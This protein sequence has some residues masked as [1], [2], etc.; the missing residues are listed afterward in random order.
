MM[1]K[2]ETVSNYFK[3]ILQMKDQVAAIGDSVDDAE[4]VTTTLNVFP[5][6][7]D[8]FVQGICARGKLS[9]FDKLWT[10]CTY[11]ESRLISKSQKTNDE[12][13]QALATHVKKRKKCIADEG[14]T[15]PLQRHP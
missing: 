2:S 15:H 7:W 6:S 4:L 5:S 9:K 13:N 12:E 10:D 1:N 14:T 3:R 11:E 8:P